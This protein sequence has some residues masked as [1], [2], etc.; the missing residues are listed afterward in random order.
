MP[1]GKKQKRMP[2]RLQLRLALELL[3]ARAFPDEAGATAIEYA[4]IASGIGAAVAATV[5]SLGSS[6]SGFYSHLSSLF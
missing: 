2:A 1:A 4:L 3:R 6:T 5:Y